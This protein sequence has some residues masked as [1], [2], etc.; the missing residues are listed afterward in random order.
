MIESLTLKIE[1]GNDAEAFKREILY[2]NPGDRPKLSE[3]SPQNST[4]RSC[5][6]QKICSAEG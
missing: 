4:I 6:C 5:L 1:V 3:C 2:T